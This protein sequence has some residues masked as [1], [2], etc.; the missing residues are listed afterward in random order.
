MK[1]KTDRNMRVVIDS[2]EIIFEKDVEYNTRNNSLRFFD[3]KCWIGCEQKFRDQIEYFVD[4][5]RSDGFRE[6]KFNWFQVN[7]QT[8][9]RK[10]IDTPFNIVITEAKTQERT[11]LVGDFEVTVTSNQDEGEVFDSEVTFSAGSVTIPITLDTT[12]GDHILT[13]Q[14]EDLDV[15]ED[16]NVRIDD[17]E[18]DVQLQASG[19]KGTEIEFNLQVTNGKDMAGDDLTGSVGVVVVSDIDGELFD[20]GVTFT[21]GGGI[22]PITLETLGE[23]ILNVT[24]DGVTDTEEVEVTVVDISDFE[25]QLAIAGGKFIDT[26]FNLAV[27]Q[28]V[29]TGGT[30]LTGTIGVVVTSNLEEAVFDDDLTFT[31]GSATI[32]ITLEEQD[33]HTL[34]VD[35]DGITEDKTLTVVVTDESDFTVQLEAETEKVTTVEFNLQITGADDV[36]G[37]PLQGGKDVVVVSDIDGEVFNGSRTFTIGDA[38]VPITLVGLGEHVLTVEVDGVT[39]TKTVTVTVQDNSEF[40]AQLTAAGDKTTAMAFT[41]DITGGKDVSGNN[42]TGDIVVTIVSDNTTEGTGG[43]VFDE[44]VTFI[45][46]DATPSITLVELGE[47]EL[48]V[49]IADVQGSETITVVVIE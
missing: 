27:T 33:T 8:P 19:S 10:S 41:I 39:D 2:K 16:L 37:T 18:F 6:I 26:E 5:N 44:Q 15:T 35:I 36:T 34:T 17:S 38:T 20:D 47:H 29:D 4:H 30:Q 9:G 24:I 46:G 43:V 25:V 23:H 49:T 32:P 21:T 45:T 42:L 7:L 28:A 31:T 22:I 40:S 14:I 3:T 1:F 11:P 12:L 48:T 13:V